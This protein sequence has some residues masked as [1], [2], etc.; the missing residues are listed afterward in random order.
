[1]KSLKRI[2]I[3]FILIIFTL[4]IFVFFKNKYEIKQMIKLNSIDKAIKLKSEVSVIYF[5]SNCPFCKDF[6]N[7]INSYLSLNENKI[8]YFDTDKFRS[9][10]KLK[11]I[12]D[13]YEVKEV[14]ALV[15]TNNNSIEKFDGEDLSKFLSL[16]F[17]YNKFITKINTITLIFLTILIAFVGISFFNNKILYILQ[18][19]LYILNIYVLY[20]IYRINVEFSH[21]VIENDFTTKDNYLFYF[22]SLCLIFLTSSQFFKKSTDICE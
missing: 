14:P 17:E 16:N 7:K 1:M 20:L 21:F 9:D 18:T 12:L 4:N 2:Y 19:I 6:E 13:L 11:Y 8:Y 3:V 15:K 22:V 5:G 10:D